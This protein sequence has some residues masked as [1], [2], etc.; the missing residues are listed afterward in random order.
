MTNLKTWTSVTVDAE[1]SALD[2]VK[3][4]HDTNLLAMVSGGR[5][6]I[7]GEESYKLDNYVSKCSCIEFSDDSKILAAGFEDGS[8]FVY[9]LPLQLNGEMTVEKVDL[10]SR[11]FF[12]PGGLNAIRCLAFNKDSSLLAYANDFGSV[13]VVSVTNQSSVYLAFDCHRSKPLFLSFLR[14]FNKSEKK[15]YLL[16]CSENGKIILHYPY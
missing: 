12:L 10:T 14:E 8:I 4:S 6:T 15:E 16:S 1:D 7:W 2:F 9:K 11:D 13:E 3:S 5:V